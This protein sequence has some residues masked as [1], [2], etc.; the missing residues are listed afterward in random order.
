[1]VCKLV[2]SAHARER[3][4]VGERDTHVSLSW[5]PSYHFVIKFVFLNAICANLAFI[6]RK[7]RHLDFELVDVVV[8]V[9]LRR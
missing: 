3:M 8:V 1:M 9:G 5:L 2:S 6:T 4:R 7:L